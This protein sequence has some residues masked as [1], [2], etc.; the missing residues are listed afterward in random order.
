MGSLLS[1]SS[2]PPSS[3]QRRILANDATSP[4]AAPSEPLFLDEVKAEP[5]AWSEESMCRTIQRFLGLLPDSA[6]R[7]KPPLRCV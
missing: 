3:E 2:P 5:A 1:T 7:C 6:V 4:T